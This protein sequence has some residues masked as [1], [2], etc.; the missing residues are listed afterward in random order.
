MITFNQSEWANHS[1]YSDLF[2]FQFWNPNDCRNLK[3]E[4]LQ[5]RKLLLDT[6][7][8]STNSSSY[9]NNQTASTS[10]T[11]NITIPATMAST[12]TIAWPPLPPPR[13]PQPPLAGLHCHHH[14]IL[15]L[16]WLAS[17]A[18]TTVSSTTLGWPPL[19]PPQYPQPPL[20][21]LHY[22][23]RGLHYHHHGPTAI[24]VRSIEIT[25]WPEWSKTQKNKWTV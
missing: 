25:E 8:K 13:Y 14:S 2:L 19:Q 18:T 10:K 22:H 9:T 5:T 17:I 15:N 11:S 23:H 16:P 3:L 21:G 20:A 6:A 4:R 1:R 12:T 24:S 7:T